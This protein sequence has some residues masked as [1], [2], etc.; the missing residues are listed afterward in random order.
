MSL[1]LLRIRSQGCSGL[2]LWASPRH[3][4]GGFP[5]CQGRGTAG[6]HDCPLGVWTVNTM[7]QDGVPGGSLEP[8][9]QEM[10]I[11]FLVP[12]AWV[13]GDGKSSGAR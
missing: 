13:T 2:S 11:C 9:A 8:D 1:P 12:G 4:Q 7:L 6:R 5:P 3:S 10:E